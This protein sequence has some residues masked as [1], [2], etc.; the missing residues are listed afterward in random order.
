MDEDNIATIFAPSIF[1]QTGLSMADMVVTMNLQ[2]QFLTNLLHGMHFPPWGSPDDEAY[3]PS[4]TPRPPP[5]SSLPR[6]RPRPRPTTFAHVT[7]PRIVCVWLWL[8]G[9]VCVVCVVPC[10]VPCVA[11]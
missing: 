6:P 7:E 1:R 2:G 8:C 3:N 10:A 9:C 11:T 5:L 4:T